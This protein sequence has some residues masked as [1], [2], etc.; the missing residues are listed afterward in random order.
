MRFEASLRGLDL[1]A[2]VA[3]GKDVGKLLPLW[4][5]GVR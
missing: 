5:P 2:D 4:R 3:W 1:Q